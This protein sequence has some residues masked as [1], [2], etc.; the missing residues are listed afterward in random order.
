L[1]GFDRNIYVV[2]KSEIPSCLR[3]REGQY[4]CPSANACLNT[5][6]T[7][8]NHQCNNDKICDINEGC[9]CSDCDDKQDHCAAGLVCTYNQ[10]NP[11]NS[12]CTRVG[13]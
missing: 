9:G 4:W 10:T 6:E 3:C 5:G 11:N 13:C 8:T 12:S 7:C 1:A 2:R